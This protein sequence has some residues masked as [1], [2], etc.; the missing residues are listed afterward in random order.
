MAA[1]NLLSG[2][3]PVQFQSPV[4]FR[5]I[6]HVYVT[7]LITAGSPAVV[8]A[9]SEEKITVTDSGAGRY[10]IGNLPT[11]G[12]SRCVA[13]GGT[14]ESPSTTYAAASVAHTALSIANGTVEINV[15]N[16]TTLTDPTTLSK[17]RYK[18]ELAVG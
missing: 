11:K 3:A 4:R 14:I 6:R 8:V 17:V 2:S 15:L 7:L 12:A 16:G 18:L 13:G 9:E 10:T 5:N 1:Q